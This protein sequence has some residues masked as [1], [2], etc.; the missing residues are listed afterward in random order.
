LL[1]DLRLPPSKIKDI[2]PHLSTKLCAKSYHVALLEGPSK[3]PSNG[4]LPYI[5]LGRQLLTVS[6]L[7]A[8][9]EPLG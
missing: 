4:G 5:G 2:T 9:G 8:Y 6:M 7:H 1:I 3:D